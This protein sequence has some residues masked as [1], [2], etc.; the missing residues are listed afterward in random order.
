ML[1]ERRE[2][3]IK[4]LAS[5]IGCTPGSA[6]VAVKRLQKG[7]LVKRERGEKDERV[8]RVSLARRGAIRLDSWRG[9]QLASMSGLF[10]PLSAKDRRALR[11]LLQKAIAATDGSP[12][13]RAESRG[14]RT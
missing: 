5:A 10:D 7:G 11:G 3:K 9:K 12:V 1:S 13:L 14:G 8:V 4:D 6:S 2:M